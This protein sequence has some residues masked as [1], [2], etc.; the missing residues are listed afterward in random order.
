[1]HTAAVWP[2]S[3]GPRTLK[4][5]KNISVPLAHMGMSHNGCEDWEQI[6]QHRSASMARGADFWF[7]LLTLG[8]ELL[9]SPG[10]GIQEGIGGGHILR[11]MAG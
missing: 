9:N 6:P 2:A 7:K 4:P 10:A 3:T 5:L 8:A 1:M 11:Q